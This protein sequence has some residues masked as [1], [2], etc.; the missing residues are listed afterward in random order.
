MFLMS[1]LRVC[2]WNPES[3]DP[4]PGSYSPWPVFELLSV[5]DEKT[6]DQPLLDILVFNNSELLG[7]LSKA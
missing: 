3:L 6:A 5:L 4:T 1:R 7:I 2:L